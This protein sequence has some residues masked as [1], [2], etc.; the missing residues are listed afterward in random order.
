QGRYSEA[1]PLYQQALQIGIQAFGEVHPDV[2]IWCNNLAGLY[3]T[4]QRYS[5]AE[6]LYL[7]AL[8]VFLDRLGED[9]PYTQN[10]YQGL[11]NLIA[12]AVQ[13]GR[14]S[15]LSD[16]PFVQDVVKQIREQRES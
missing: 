8:G 1:E 5:E 6:P 16:H 15:E 11:V 14:E 12:E 10:T 2:A 13:A 4:L 3:T 9:H 7:H